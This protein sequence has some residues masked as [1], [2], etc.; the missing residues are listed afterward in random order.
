MERISLRGLS[1]EEIGRRIYLELMELAD[2]VTWRRWTGKGLDYSADKLAS[3]A[4]LAAELLEHLSASQS[5]EERAMLV[6]AARQK[7]CWPVVLRPG[8]KRNR[9]GESITT[10]VGIKKAKSY[11]RAIELGRDAA[12]VLGHIHDR[13]ANPFKRTAELLLDELLRWREF[14]AWRKPISPW[15][16]KLLSLEYPMTSENVRQ[17]WSLAKEWMDETW[18]S[19]S[20]KFEPLVKHLNLDRKKHTPSLVKRQVIDDSLKKAFVTLAAVGNL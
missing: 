12:S 14:G 11:L 13:E 4:I 18:R 17:W 20:E 16:K 7:L 10:V 8:V 15:N 9:A 3:A 5:R 19:N 1:T 2:R 6:R